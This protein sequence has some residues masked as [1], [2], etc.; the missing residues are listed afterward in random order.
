MIYVTDYQSTAGKPIPPVT[1]FNLQAESLHGSPAIARAPHVLR[2]DRASTPF[3]FFISA[4]ESQLLSPTNFT[5]TSIF[6]LSADYPMSFLLLLLGVF[7][8]NEI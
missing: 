6:L 8:I 3:S 2:E 4:S 5:E 1:A 7:C